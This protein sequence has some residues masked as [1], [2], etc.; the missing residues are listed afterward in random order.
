LLGVTITYEERHENLREDIRSG[1]HK[2]GEELASGAIV[3]PF[4]T[5]GDNYF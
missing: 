4:F 2:Y 3:C 5:K 1:V